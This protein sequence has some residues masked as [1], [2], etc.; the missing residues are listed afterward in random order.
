MLAITLIMQNS[1]NTHVYLDRETFVLYYHDISLEFQCCISSTIRHLH[2]FNIIS[3]LEFRK[4]QYKKAI[5]DL[6]LV[7]FSQ[8][9]GE[10]TARQTFLFEISKKIH[11][12]TQLFNFSTTSPKKTTPGKCFYYICVLILE[13][14]PCSSFFT[15]FLGQFSWKDMQCGEFTAEH[16]D[17]A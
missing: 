6:D 2:F 10:T 8:T 9:Q 5:S 7:P 15:L 16:Y 1:K 17:I 11:Q 3:S 12:Q 13:L 4:L 14:M